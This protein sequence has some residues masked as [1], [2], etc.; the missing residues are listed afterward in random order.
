[1]APG[2]PIMTPDRRAYK[3]RAFTSVVNESVCVTMGVTAPTC[4]SPGP[5][6]VMSETYSPSFDPENITTNWV[7]DLGNSPPQQASYG[8]NVPAGAR[9]ETVVDEVLNT[10]NCGGVNLTWS[11]DRPWARARPIPSGLTAVGQTLTSSF[12]VWPDSPAVGRQ[13][14][15]CDAAGGSCVDI[16][17]ATGQ[18]YVPTDDDVGHTIGIDESATEGGLTSTV[19]GRTTITPVFIPAMTIEG[20]SLGAGDPAMSGRLNVTSPPSSCAAPKSAP[21][22]TGNEIFFYDVF[23]V[24]S[25]I[26]EPACVFVAHILQPSG[27]FCSSG[28]VLY[29]ADVRPRQPAGQLRRGRLSHRDTR[30][31]AR[32]GRI[33]AGRDLRRRLVPHVFRLRTDDRIR[34]ALRD[35]SAAA[36]GRLDGGDPRYDHDRRLERRPGVRVQLAAV[37]RERRRLRPDRR[38]NRAGLHAHRRRRRLH[39]AGASDGDAGRAVGFVG[40]GTDGRDRGS[41]AARPDRAEGE[42]SGS[43]HATSRRSSRADGFR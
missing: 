20:Q 22:I 31:H 42:R 4:A 26:N 34:C 17:G 32:A 8:F 25:L 7:G 23:A 10:A 15:R 43:G 36:G 24:R 13:W 19:E 9:F 21:A 12:D 2:S 1:M 30:G 40:L 38:G 27:G 14:K 29:C 3:S 28:L 5:N 33:R 18:N 39:A 37:R 35:R 16:P 11:S 6:E 41:A